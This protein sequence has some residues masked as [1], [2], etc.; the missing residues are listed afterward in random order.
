M[1]NKGDVYMYR[2]DKS[3]AI[4][5][6]D[7]HFFIWPEHISY[8]ISSIYFTWDSGRIYKDDMYGASEDILLFDCKRYMKWEEN[9]D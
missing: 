3:I 4:Q 2:E 8:Q 1:L 7:G 6:K 9:K 5:M